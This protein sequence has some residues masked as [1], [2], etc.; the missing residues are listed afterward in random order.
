MPGHLR[1]KCYCIHG[2][3]AWHKMFGKPKPK[4]KL[5]SPRGSVVA[6]V[7]HDSSNTVS[8]GLQSSSDGLNLSEG[9]CRQL[10]TMLQKNLTVTSPQIQST[11]HSD[12]EA[13]YWMTSANAVRFSGMVCSKQHSVNH[14]HVLDKTLLQSK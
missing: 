9:Q 7:V 2:F 11:Q 1:D 13:T 8:A 5:L 6:S 12:A 4:P 10:I 3:P 14:I